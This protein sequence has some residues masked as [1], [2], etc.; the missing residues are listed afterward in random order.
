MTKLLFL[1]LL[2]QHAFAQTAEQKYLL[3][4][5]NNDVHWLHDGKKE[6][7]KRGTFL[8]VSQSIILPQKSE[9]MFVQH[10]GKSLLL[11]KP[12]TYTFT[13]IQQLFNSSAKRSV[14]TAFFSYVFEKFLSN[15]DAEEKQKVSASVFRGKKAMQLP[16]DSTFIL[17]FPITL[18]WKPEQKNIPYK[19]TVYY[20]KLKID[21]VV[22][23]KN[24]FQLPHSIISDSTAALLSWNT[25]PSDSK[26][27]PT[28][29]LAIIPAIIDI[30]IIQQQLTQLR[31]AYSKQPAML[32]L[33]EKDLFERW[34]ELYQLHSPKEELPAQ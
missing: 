16:A 14:S 27:K 9:V 26:Q 13:R 33:M 4:N 20:R 1:L 34:M 17:S 31:Q 23:S 18:Q 11:S 22:L 30:D 32:R 6:K 2:L 24:S 15:D 8:L 25:M 21:T 12:G 19:L 10:D 3:Y 5:V 28:F 29:F 7:A